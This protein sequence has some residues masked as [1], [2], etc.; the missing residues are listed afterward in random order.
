MDILKRDGKQYYIEK[1]NIYYAATLSIVPDPMC[2]GYMATNLGDTIAFINKKIINPDPRNVVNPA[3]TFLGDSRS[4]MLHKNDLYRG[5]LDLTFDTAAPGTN[6]KVE[7]T[8]IVYFA[9][10]T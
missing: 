7:I 8:Q 9:D 1:V 4:V 2:A 3:N 5:R 10:E 6:P